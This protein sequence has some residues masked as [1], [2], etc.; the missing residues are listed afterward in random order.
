MEANSED[1][2][3]KRAQMQSS[4]EEKSK[5]VRVREYQSDRSLRESNDRLPQGESRSVQEPPARAIHPSDFSCTRLLDEINAKETS[6]YFPLQRNPKIWDLESALRYLIQVEGD[7][8]EYLGENSDATPWVTFRAGHAG[9]ASVIAQWYRNSSGMESPEMEVSKAEE[10][11]E[12]GQDESKTSMLELWL[13]DGLGDEDTPPAIHA[14]LAQVHGNSED[15]NG[16]T[17]A[18]GAVGLLTLAWDQGERTLRVEWIH[19]DST[20]EKTF[21]TVLEQ[22]IWLRI[23]ALAHMTACQLVVVDESLISQTAKPKSRTNEKPSP[24]AE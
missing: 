15:G 4:E 17:S 14:L 24:R 3:K 8:K 5:K 23:S 12:S 1:A 7:V 16:I 21:A 10:S 9:D 13:A 20:I 2:R 22:R 11:G 18:L 6:T 19:I